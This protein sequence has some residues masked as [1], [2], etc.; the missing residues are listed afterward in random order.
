MLTKKTINDLTK[1]DFTKSQLPVFEGGIY[2][3]KLNDDED[4]NR[5]YIVTKLNRFES[6]FSA[7]AIQLAR[8]TSRESEFWNI[9]LVL[10]N[11][12]SFIDTSSLVFANGI[13]FFNK[14]TSAYVGPVSIVP[15]VVVDLTNRIVYRH[16]ID[17][18]EEY[19]ALVDDTWQYIKRI[20]TF[21]VC[22]YE[23]HYATSPHDYESG[24]FWPNG[25]R[26]TPIKNV[27][28]KSSVVGPKFSS[29]IYSEDSKEEDIKEEEVVEAPVKV[30][31]E[32]KEEPPVEPVKEEA[33]IPEPEVTQ[34][35]ETETSSEQTGWNTPGKRR[36]LNTLTEPEKKE[37]IEHCKKYPEKGFPYHD[38]AENLKHDYIRLYEKY[39]CSILAHYT[40][41]SLTIACRRYYTFKNEIDRDVQETT[42]DSE[43]EFLTKKDSTTK[44]V[45]VEVDPNVTKSIKELI[46]RALPYINSNRDVFLVPQSPK[47]FTEKFMRTFLSEDSSVNTSVRQLQ[48]MYRLKK[49]PDVV[50]LRS[51]IHDEF[52]KRGLAKLDF[53]LKKSMTVPTP[54]KNPDEEILLF[55]CEASVYPD[56][57]IQSVYDNASG[58]NID[59]KVK[60]YLAYL[61]GKKIAG[62]KISF[63]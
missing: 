22:V 2:Y 45:P 21:G 17:S 43:S 32:V 52:A 53:P 39:S 40:G 15:P 37:L 18:E 59:Q 54:G 7:K 33:A 41:V 62:L 10:Q 31:E 30:K 16:I 8:I 48:S 26:R 51:S 20:E 42:S 5:P 56:S 28:Y 25:S 24:Q 23:K 1:E 38:W 44:S 57:V 9:P 46:N 60:E 50:K 4:F 12:I 14:D 34:N 11:K 27:P 13:Q 36:R 29:H 61:D 35:E 63:S 3:L 6:N 49:Q 47:D 58:L 55:V 19:N